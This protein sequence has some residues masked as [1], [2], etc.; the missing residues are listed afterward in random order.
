MDEKPE[1][2]DDEMLDDLDFDDELDEGSWD[3][4]DDEETSEEPEASN[5]DNIAEPQ[6]Q[7]KKGFVSKNF[8]LIVIGVAV[9][10]AGGW[11]LTQMSSP[12]TADNSAANSVQNETANIADNTIIEEPS[13]PTG[14]LS[15]NS[16]LPPMP[17][18]INAVEAEIKS[19][20]DADDLAN[21]LTPMPV[22]SEQGTSE[23]SDDNPVNDLGDVLDI[24]AD[25]VVNPEP[26]IPE[27]SMEITEAAP[28]SNG[29]DALIN[30]P[31]DA[32]STDIEPDFDAAMLEPIEDISDD[33]DALPVKS[34]LPVEI[35]PEPVED[36]I[37]I[38]ESIKDE[39]AINEAPVETTSIEIENFE[40][41][42]NSIEESNSALKSQLSQTN[43]SIHALSGS[44]DA[45]QKTL[46]DISKKQATL[47]SR[48]ETVEKPAVKAAPKA[49]PVKT[50]EPTPAVPPKQIT[51]PSAPIAKQKTI[52]AVNW[53]LRSA[54]PGKALLFDK[55]TGQ[56]RDV[57]VGDSVNSLG[58]ITSVKVENGLW[59]VRGTKGRVSQ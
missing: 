52:V 13:Q 56:V 41:R 50:V 59:V 14:V 21:I 17:A 20:S 18:P 8:N 4:F 48:T 10:G 44:I 53:G 9:L 1:D 7:K 51:K 57:K 45:I 25:N 11:F 2:F 40:E 35:N 33:A 37:V 3:D 30:D 43:Q 16:A 6:T 54:Q 29:I 47:A 26:V 23:N 42:I 46:E 55:K 49:E 19:E 32:D 5:D 39:L 15:D 22:A 24:P 12:Q 28:E 38:A 31:V 36:P 34:E 58:R 27:T